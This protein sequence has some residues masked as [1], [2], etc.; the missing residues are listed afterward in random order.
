MSAPEDHPIDTLPLQPTQPAAQSLYAPHGRPGAFFNPWRRFDRTFWDLL[1]WR[2][3]G[4]PGNRSRTPIVPRM[5]NDGARFSGVAEV[6]AVT[7]VGHCTFAIHDGDDVVLTDPH[8]GPRALWPRRQVEPGIPLASVPERAFAVLS[9]SHYD[10]L[11]ATSV[12]AL[13]RALQ[14]FVPL[15]LGAWFRRHGHRR[16]V[17]LDWWQRVRHGRWTLICLPAQHWSNRLSH[18]IHGTLWCSWLLD[19]GDRRYY[20]GGDSGYFPGFAE[21]GQR[22]SGIDVAL[23]SIGAYEP[24]WFMRY[25][26]MDPAEAYRAFLDLGARH[27]IPMHWGTFKLADEPLDQPPKALARAVEAAGGDPRVHT[28][29]IGERWEIPATVPS[30]A[31]DPRQQ[32]RMGKELEKK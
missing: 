21:I 31:R 6:P 12:R 14:W 4:G 17:E 11:D 10:H 25:Q 19:S 26:H 3:Q 8:F 28:L 5:A 1:R 18:P 9:H 16:V 30:R 23:L 29:A 20:F 15:G 22:F 32:A 27:L 13:P 2:L 24:R 7:W